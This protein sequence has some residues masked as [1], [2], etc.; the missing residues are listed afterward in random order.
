MTRTPKPDRQLSQTAV[1]YRARDTAA[2]PWCWDIVQVDA[3]GAETTIE[4][5]TID[6]LGSELRAIQGVDDAQEGAESGDLP[7]WEQVVDR[8]WLQ[9]IADAAARCS[10][11]R[12]STPLLRPAEDDRAD[13]K[14][15]LAD[16]LDATEEYVTW[17]RD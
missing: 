14:R 7:L 10:T 4:T 11:E 6:E 16:L 13:M 12:K 8:A 2:N 15:L 3:H 5:C 1:R 9:R 17:C